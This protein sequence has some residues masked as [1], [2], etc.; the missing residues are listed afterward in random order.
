MV[1]IQLKSGLQSQAI[2]QLYSYTPL[3][4]R[5]FI[6]THFYQQH[7]HLLQSMSRRNELEE[8]FDF[9]SKEHERLGEEI[10]FLK[11]DLR[12]SIGNHRRRNI[13][14]TE[15]GAKFVDTLN[16]YKVS[17]LFHSRSSNVLTEDLLIK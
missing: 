15:K 8:E 3:N 12:T 14:I 9:I 17:I 5:E 7:L 10:N 11:Q 16:W 2:M 4:E 13:G 1:P 6:S